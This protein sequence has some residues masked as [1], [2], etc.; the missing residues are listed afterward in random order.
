MFLRVLDPSI[1]IDIPVVPRL[2]IM[3]GGIYRLRG[4]GGR[5]VNIGRT[6]TVPQCPLPERELR[7]WVF[8]NGFIP[9]VALVEVLSAGISIHNGIV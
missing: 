8:Q 2:G 3:L 6:M 5:C 1:H 9:G 7:L 4:A